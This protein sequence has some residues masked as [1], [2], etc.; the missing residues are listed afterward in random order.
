MTDPVPDSHSLLLVEDDLALC[1]YLASALRDGG[2]SVSLAHDRV[3]GQEYFKG[4][5]CP[6]LV[7]LDL[8]LPP[9]PSTMAE[10]L[11][12][13]DEI[14]R[15]APMAKVI[16]LTGQDEDAAADT[17][18]IPRSDDLRYIPQPH[19]EQEQEQEQEHNHGEQDY[20]LNKTEELI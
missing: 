2:Y 3:Q 19:D 11:A 15:L 8:G 14:L 4:P 18:A 16:V 12:L 1:G 13:L 6:N 10:G 20:D 17:Q 9:Q 5:N 7:L